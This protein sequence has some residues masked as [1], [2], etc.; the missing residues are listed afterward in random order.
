MQTKSRLCDLTST[1]ML[2]LYIS[3]VLPRLFVLTPTQAIRNAESA[4]GV[5]SNNYVHI[6]AMNE[7]WGSGD[8]NQYLTNTNF[9][10]Y[11]D[12]RYLKWDTSVTVSQAAYLQN[13]CDANRNSDNDTPTIVGEFSI[14]VPDDVQDDADW[15]TSTQTAFYK[16]WFA[17]Q[18]SNFESNTNGWVFWS[19]K[20]QLGDYRWSY[21]G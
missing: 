2:T 16:Q 12:H 19:W 9:M 14:S 21:Q 8:P 11:D 13:S 20:A 3:Q 1:P 5:A 6:E 18:V 15:S 7:L 10:A 17:A 4:L